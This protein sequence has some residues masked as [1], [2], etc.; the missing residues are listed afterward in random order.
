MLTDREILELFELL[1]LNEEVERNK[2]LPRPLEPGDGWTIE[3]TIQLTNN[4]SQPC[5]V[6]NARLERTSR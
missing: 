6:L 5:G 2:Y 4:T 1:K 3:D